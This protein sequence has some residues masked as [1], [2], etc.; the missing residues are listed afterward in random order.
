MH[1]RENLIYAA[2]S[3]NVE[4]VRR[5]LQADPGS[6][7]V[8]DSHIGTTP[9]HCAAHRGFLEITQALIEAGADVNSREVCCAAIPLHWAA[10]GGHLEVARLLI[11]RG[12][13]LNAIDSWHDL[14]PLGWA[15]AIQRG[16]TTSQQEVAG[17]LLDHGARPDIF[18]AIV[19]NNHNAARRLIGAEPG[20]I[21]LRMGVVDNRQQP[22]HFAVE[23]NHP[24]MT[25]LLL[26]LGANMNSKTSWGVTP[27]CL[28]IV[29]HQD[30]IVEMLRDR[31][32]EVDLSA[33]LALGEFDRADEMLKSDPSLVGPAGAY[34]LLTHFTT[35]GNMAPA[36]SVLLDN[37][38]DP[39]V[40]AEHFHAERETICALSPLHV[41]AWHGHAEVARI[42]LDHGAS[43]SLQDDK[44]ESTPFIWAKWH[45]HDDLSGLLRSA[46]APPPGIFNRLR[47]W[48]SGV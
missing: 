3:G 28:A 22:L 2:C 13:D 43:R 11:N 34:R 8:R 31:G 47:R 15:G 45:H 38:A 19:V 37:G 32:A 5:I 25:R 4:W 27:L 24:E 29:R 7:N 33:A 17:L 40:I 48:W 44:Y 39:N 35:K 30:Q 14:G 20:A 36:T 16:R 9:L 6:V 26:D 10:E 42:L 1:A 41:A 12:S 46:E 23:C 18:S 21:N